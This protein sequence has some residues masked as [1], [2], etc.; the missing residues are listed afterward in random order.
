MN[1]TSM[2]IF[3]SLIFFGVSCANNTGEERFNHQAWTEEVNQWHDNRIESLKQNDSW[4]TLAGFFWLNEAI[5]TFGSAPDN[6]LVFQYPEAPGHMGS[7]HV[8]GHKVRVEIEEGVEILIDDE[9]K[10]QALIY[11]EDMDD[12]AVMEWGSLN[13]YVIKRSGGYA[14]RL[15]D[16]EHPLLSNFTGIDRFPVNS[17]WRIR[18]EF[19]PFDTPRRIT[20]PNYIGEP[21]EESVLGILEFEV[22]GATYQ[23]HPLAD[24]PD[25]RF[26][27]IFADLTNG[28]KTYSAGRFV[29]TDPPDENHIVYIDFNKSYNPPCVFSE[30]ATC[31]LPPPENRLPITVEAGEYNFSID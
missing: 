16:R 8:D 11:D 30:F 7:F 3:L 21:T 1:A 14:I 29:Y 12:V 4:L 15:R 23:L 10:S 17:E 5:S 18:A 6:D 2:V 31:P 28:T 26:F 25:E 27:I 20:V 9:P 13:W 19:K 22:D 24:N